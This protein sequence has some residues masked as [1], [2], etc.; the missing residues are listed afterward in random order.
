MIKDSIKKYDIMIWIF[1]F[2]RMINQYRLYKTTIFFCV[3]LLYA[4]RVFLSLLLPYMKAI[5]S[6]SSNPKSKTERAG[7]KCKKIPYL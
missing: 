1:F 2:D 4:K 3:A 5:L 7:R 6:W